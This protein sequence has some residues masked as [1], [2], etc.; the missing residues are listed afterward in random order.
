MYK[1]FQQLG[2]RLSFFLFPIC[3]VVRSSH[4]TSLVVPVG[5]SPP[6]KRTH[7]FISYR[8]LSIAHKFVV[9][10][11]LLPMLSMSICIILSH[12][13]PTSPCPSGAS[14]LGHPR[15]QLHPV[16]AL[17]DVPQRGIHHP[18]LLQHGGPLEGRARD[19]NGVH[20]AAAA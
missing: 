6:V 19:V 20:A 3:F 15:I 18:L 11:W 4:C 16:P 5:D 8:S 7:C 9:D 12:L 13:L 2:R 14:L 10:E 1:S 17:H